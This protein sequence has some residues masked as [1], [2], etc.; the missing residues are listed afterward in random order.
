MY[1][2][3]SATVWG[4]Q[5]CSRPGFELTTFRC[6]VPQPNQNTM[7]SPH[8]R[9]KN[10]SQGSSKEIEKIVKHLLRSDNNNL[11]LRLLTHSSQISCPL[12]NFSTD[13]VHALTVLIGHIFI[14]YFTTTFPRMFERAIT[15][16]PKTKQKIS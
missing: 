5:L 12:A 13:Q 2:S 11:G 4:F 6:S 3:R 15:G 8:P 9:E 1:S 16:V 10:F 7:G 14:S